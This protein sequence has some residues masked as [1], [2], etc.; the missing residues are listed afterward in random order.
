M[1]YI[2]IIIIFLSVIG[3]S[4]CQNE[5]PQTPSAIVIPVDINESFSIPASDENITK[6]IIV[7]LNES[8]INTSKLYW[9]V[10]C[11][12][13]VN[14]TIGHADVDSDGLSYD[15]STPGYRGHEGTDIRISWEQMDEGVSVFAA[16]SGTVLW[17]FDDMN[18]YDRC[19]ENNTHKDC[20]APT[21]SLQPNLNS[22][23]AVCTE[24]GSYCKKDSGYSQC[25]WCFYG[26]NVIVIKH[27]SGNVAFTRYDHLKSASVLVH[28]GDYVSRGQKIAEVGSAG[29]S[30]GP[31]LHFEVWMNDYY[32]LVEPFFGK[33]GPNFSNGLWNY[34]NEPWKINTQ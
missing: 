2:N 28:K 3:L 12:P 9:P 33:C 10:D 15:C 11:M 17:V 24:L 4:A 20:N 13:G 16:Q 8:L 19:T 7:D 14:C 34:E 22:G 1:Q 5:K 6:E 29:K 25:Y 27:D 31:H 21:V 18:V 32:D 23:Y 30:T 26:K